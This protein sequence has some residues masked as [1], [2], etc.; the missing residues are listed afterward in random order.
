MVPD[1]QSV[2]P[3]TSIRD[4]AYEQL[5]HGIITGQ[6]PAGTRIVETVYA[7][8]LHISRT[9]LREAL[10]RLQDD[11]LVEY[12]PHH[13]VIVKAFTISDIEEIF[14]IRNAMMMLLLPSIIENVC[15]KDIRFL[16]DILADMDQALSV[17]DVEKLALLN[18]KFHRTI[19]Q[20][21]D[22]HRILHVIDSQEE[23]I[24]RFSAMAIASV[25]RRTHAHEE[26]HQMVE[27]LEKKDLAALRELM[28]HHLEESKTT[29]LNAMKGRDSKA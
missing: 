1:F 22:K 19:E 7:E 20:L 10:H 4:V 3:N 23:Y 28:Q 29:C 27:L 6:I 9:P 21:S 12:I 14:I 18:R 24:M 17:E 2:T 5:K 25:V 16:K 26:H 11:D 8:F 13:G 15:Q